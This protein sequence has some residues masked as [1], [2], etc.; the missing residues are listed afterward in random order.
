MNFIHTYIEQVIQKLNE[1]VAEEKIKRKGAE[2]DLKKFQKNSTELKNELENIKR[3]NSYLAKKLREI[4]E[5][6]ICCEDK[7]NRVLS[8]GHLFCSTCAMRFFNEEK[9]PQCQQKP[10]GI[11]AIFLE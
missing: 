2:R 7:C 8:C 4:N 10:L 1:K 11:H 5:C 3:Q 6:Q 9:C